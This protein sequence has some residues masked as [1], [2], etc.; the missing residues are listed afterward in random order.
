MKK[1]ILAALIVCLA[2]YGGKAQTYAIL[3]S[4]SNNGNGLAWPCASSSGG[5][6]PFNAIP[7]SQTRGASYCM[8]PGTYSLGTTTVL[9][10]PDSGTSTITL[11]SPTSTNECSLVSG[12]NAIADVGQ[13]ETGPLNFQSDYWT[14]SGEYRS[15]STGNPWTDWF[16]EA[17]YG[18]KVDNQ[19]SYNSGTGVGVPVNA[20]AAIIA[21]IP[22]TSPVGNITVQYVDIQGSGDV[23]G[24]TSAKDDG[25][26]TSWAEGCPTAPCANTLPQ[27]IPGITLTKSY[28]HDLG[29]GGGFVCDSCTGAAVTYNG[30]DRAEVTPNNHSEMISF[31]C[32]QSGSNVTGNDANETIAYNIVW[33]DNATA[34]IATP[35]Q[36]DIHPSTWDI[37]GNFFGV[38]GSRM[39]TL[40]TCPSNPTGNQLECGVGDG[41]LSLWNFTT[42]GGYLHVFNNTIYAIDDYQGLGIGFGTQGRCLHDWGGANP[43]SMGTVLFLNNIWIGCIGGIQLPTSCPATGSCTQYTDDYNSFFD[44]TGTVTAP[45]SNNQT[46]G[47]NPAVNLG[48]TAGAYNFSLASDTSTW[49]NTSSILA[50]NNTD[51]LGHTRTTS[52]GALQFEPALGPSSSVQGASVSGATIH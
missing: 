44:I 6:G 51:M 25:F 38:N 7:A 1:A 42:W 20:T 32:W 33:D 48:Q 50:A 26:H 16:V 19:A 8:G 27:S 43:T 31:R 30:F 29:L 34:D 39:N 3:S 11:L 5:A 12:F 21:G 2:Y 13:A 10:T 45:G 23:S 9:S 22:G 37:Y 41:F 17:G 4:C 47:T 24:S 35:C 28:V 18:I 40:Y 49:S 46:S 14:L 15:T 52:R 36:T